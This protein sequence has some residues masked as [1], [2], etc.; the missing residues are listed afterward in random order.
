VLRHH[1][2]LG[3]QLLK[4]ALDSVLETH[5][6]CRTGLWLVWLRILL[7]VARVHLQ[8]DRIMR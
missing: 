2:R 8:R 5:R 3:L 4:P 6:G 7:Q 1:L